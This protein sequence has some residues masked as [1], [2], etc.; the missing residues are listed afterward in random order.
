[1]H[2]GAPARR[3]RG[4]LGPGRQLSVLAASGS[5]LTSWRPAAR[6]ASAG[7]AWTRTQTVRV[8]VPY[9]SSG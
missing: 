1:M 5:I 2:R 9:G 8:P 3:G 4:V 7:F 6:A